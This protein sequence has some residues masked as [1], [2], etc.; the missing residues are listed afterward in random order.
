MDRDFTPTNDRK[1]AIIESKLRGL[2]EQRYSLEL[3]ARV[4]ARLNEAEQLGAIKKD[5]AKIESAIDLFSAE[6]AELGPAEP[7]SP[8]GRA[9]GELQPQ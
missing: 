4:N 5:L 7:A 2:A 1:R 3:D 8:N 9:H 6:L